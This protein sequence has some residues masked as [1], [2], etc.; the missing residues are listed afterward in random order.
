MQSHIPLVSLGERREKRVY[1]SYLS[2]WAWIGWGDACTRTL[3][4]VRVG[5][6]YQF[7]V[8]SF[9]QACNTKALNS[10]NSE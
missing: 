6:L 10:L 4:G 2:R 8:I 1:L 9:W 5:A 7:G 3:H